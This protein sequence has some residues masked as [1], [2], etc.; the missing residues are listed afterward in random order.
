MKRDLLTSSEVA[1]WLRLK[2]KSLAAM[3]QRGEGP[4]FIRLS[5]GHVLY[6][7]AVV[8]AW[9]ESKTINTNKEKKV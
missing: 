4:E 5:D 3:R 6:S 8:E 9:L 7:A 2:P 1:D